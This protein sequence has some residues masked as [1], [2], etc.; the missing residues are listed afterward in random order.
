MSSSFQALSFTVVSSYYALVSPCNFL[1]PCANTKVCFVK[2]RTGT[3]RFSATGGD[4]FAGGG[5]GRISVKVF[6]RHD[7][8]VFFVHGAIQ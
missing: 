2:C 5:G 3:G 4:G 7:D 6:S 8:T 1:L